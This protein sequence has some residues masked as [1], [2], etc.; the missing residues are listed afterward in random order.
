MIFHDFSIGL[1][2]LKSKDLFR[3]VVIKSKAQWP[4][5][6]YILKSPNEFHSFWII[7]ML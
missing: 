3:K 2:P 1:S 7:F 4:L 6:L 5:A